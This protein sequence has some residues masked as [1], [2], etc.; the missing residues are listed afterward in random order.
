MAL[1]VLALCLALSPLGRG[2]YR[3]FTVF[4]LPISKSFGR[5]RKSGIHLLVRRCDQRPR[6]SV[7]RPACAISPA[8]ASGPACAFAAFAW[9]V[10]PFEFRADAPSPIERLYGHARMAERRRHAVDPTAG[11]LSRPSR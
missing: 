11:S 6:L 8:H 4:L 3:S 9:L 2:I 5:D 10:L 7:D 1:T